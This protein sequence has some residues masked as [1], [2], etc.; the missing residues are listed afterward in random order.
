MNRASLEEVSTWCSGAQWGG[1]TAGLGVG[2]SL[3]TCSEGHSK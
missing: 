3:V 2:E 1:G